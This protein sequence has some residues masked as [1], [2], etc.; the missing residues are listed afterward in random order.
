MLLQGEFAISTVDGKIE[1]K[2]SW[3]VPLAHLGVWIEKTSG[4]ILPRG[5][6]FAT[7]Q[8]EEHT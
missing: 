1:R 7:C 3:R 8:I 4:N 6:I 2:R 5:Q